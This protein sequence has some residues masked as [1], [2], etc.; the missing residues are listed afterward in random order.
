MSQ[1][2]LEVVRKILQQICVAYQPEGGTKVS[3]RTHSGMCSPMHLNTMLNSCQVGAPGNGGGTSL[4]CDLLQRSKGDLEAVTRASLLHR[5]DDKASFAT[6]S[7]QLAVLLLCCVT[8]QVVVLTQ[9]SKLEME[10]IFWRC[11]PAAKRFGTRLIFR[12]GSPLVPSGDGRGGEQRDGGGASAVQH[13]AWQL[14]DRASTPSSQQ[15]STCNWRLAPELQVLVQPV[16]CYLQAAAQCNAGCLHTAWALLAA[17][18]YAMQVAQ[19]MV[20]V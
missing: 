16:H 14:A 12:Q 7:K 11:M 5:A 20:C 15:A 9:R 4:H 10:G 18:A 1:R 19:C 6:T 13:T 2:D 17:G 3:A 8:R